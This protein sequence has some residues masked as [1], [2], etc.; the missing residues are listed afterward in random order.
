MFTTIKKLVVALAVAVA[1]LSMTAQVHAVDLID[2]L[3]TDF[4]AAKTALSTA[5]S[6]ILVAAFT[7]VVAGLAYKM[8]RGGAKTIAPR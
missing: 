7:F 2:T 3:T 1:G 5:Q 8:F 6:L 4:T